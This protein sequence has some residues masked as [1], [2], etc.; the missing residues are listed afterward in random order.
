MVIGP[1]KADD[2]SLEGM[3][4]FYKFYIQPRYSPDDLEGEDWEEKLIGRYLV[5]VKYNGEEEWKPMPIYSLHRK[6]PLPYWA[7]RVFDKVSAFRILFPV[8]E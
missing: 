2:P 8:V 3:A 5:E 7:D 1:A 6:F 4:P